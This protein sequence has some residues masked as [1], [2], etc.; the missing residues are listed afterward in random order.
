MIPHEARGGSLSV[1]VRPRSFIIPT[2][3]ILA[4]AALLLVIAQRWV[5]W[6][7]N[8][9][10]KKT[11]DAYVHANIVPLSTRIS[12]TLRELNVNDY[13]SVH[14]GQLLAK[15][16]DTDY[17]SELQQAESS[18]A[19]SRAALN[20]NQVQKQVQKAS[21]ASAQQQV[22]EAVKSEDAAAADVA[23]AQA[24]AD[25]ADEERHRQ[26]ALFAENATTR[27][28]LEKAVAD[29]REA[30]AKLDGAESDR[31]KAAAAV[32]QASAT[33]LQDERSL[34]L[35]N[36]KDEDYRA[37]VRAKE[38]AVT[39]AQVQL[40]YTSIYAPADGRVGQRKVFP[41]QLVSPGVEVISLVEGDT[42]VEANYQETQL[43]GMRVGDAADIHIDA[44][45]SSSFH[46]HVREIS[47]TSGAAG[48][49][50]PPDNASGNFTKVVQRLPVKVSIDSGSVSVGELQP[51]LSAE[52]YVYASGAT[53]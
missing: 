35:L 28:K 13:Q 1:S 14:A 2:L 7:S 26:E 25:Q 39:T 30:H 6:Q 31:M 19:A 27:Q 5:F 51:G 49:L 15:L 18:L 20:D 4:A 38:A 36:S 50:L 3:I 21:I 43:A 11:N 45:P 42:W 37:D 12:D 22:E 8:R 53:R 46:G 33:V 41:G 17:Q 47:P 10:T 16:D 34:E 48:S 29:S 52:V 23:T 9:A 24:E 44:L 40:N 32:Q